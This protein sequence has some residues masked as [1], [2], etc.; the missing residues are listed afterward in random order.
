[1]NFAKVDGWSDYNIYPDGDIFSFRKNKTTLMNPYKTK[2]GYMVITLCKNGKGKK[3]YV[4]RLI[5]TTFIPNPENK[6]CVDHINGVRDDNRLENLRWLTHKENLNA[7]RT[8]RPVS[9]ITKGSITKKENSWRWR[10]S[11]SGKKK[12]KTMKSKEDLEKYRKEKLILSS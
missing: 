3:F 8:P 11:M 10:Y 6:R 1:M 12:S 9:I 2:K 7:F 4:H 5:A